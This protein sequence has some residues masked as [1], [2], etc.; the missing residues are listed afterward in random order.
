MCTVILTRVKHIKGDL[1]CWLT[2]FFSMQTLPTV[3]E[4]LTGQFGANVLRRDGDCNYKAMLWLEAI[5]VK[6]MAL[7]LLVIK[8]I[9]TQVH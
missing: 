2:Q 5:P 4:K 7:H 1:H 8:W 9:V 6:S 3:I